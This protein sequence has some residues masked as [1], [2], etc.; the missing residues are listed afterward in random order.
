MKGVLSSS[1]LSNPLD[2]NKNGVNIQCTTQRV[3]A[4]APKISGFKLI[5]FK[6]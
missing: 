4:T 3:L 5:N 6:K 2:K 1:L